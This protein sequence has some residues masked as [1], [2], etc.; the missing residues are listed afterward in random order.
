MTI[1]YVVS[2]VRY[3]QHG[4]ETVMML[5]IDV[6]TWEVLLKVLPSY[7]LPPSELCTRHSATLKLFLS[8]YHLKRFSAVS[9]LSLL[10]VIL[11]RTA[12]ILKVSC[13]LSRPWQVHWYISVGAV[14]QKS[15][16]LVT[17]NSLFFLKKLYPQNKKQNSC[18][19]GLFYILM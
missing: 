12:D 3:W 18:R 11:A 6:I 7:V 1:C 15:P 19:K 14:N 9:C 16:T 5:V 4:G 17:C 13:W 8:W 10:S 2:M